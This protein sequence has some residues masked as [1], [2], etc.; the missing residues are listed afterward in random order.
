MMPPELRFRPTALADLEAIFRSVLQISASPI[1]A[2][3]YIERIR[4]RC[5]HIATLPLAGRP[6]EDL[7]PGLR[8]VAFERRIVILY[9]VIKDSIE[10]TNIFHGARDYAALYRH[11][12][13]ND[14]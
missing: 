3:R 9:R 12:E 4:A 1:V 2:R 8:S 14:G 13:G 6:R 7:A 11:D 10:I 5:R